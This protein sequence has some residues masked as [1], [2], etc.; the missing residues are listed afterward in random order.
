M[1]HHNIHDLYMSVFHHVCVR[2]FVYAATRV[3]AYV[4][5]FDIRGCRSSSD[6]SDG[7]GV[8]SLSLFV[9]LL[10]LTHIRPLFKQNRAKRRDLHTYDVSHTRSVN[11]SGHGWKLSPE[12]Q[13]DTCG[14]IGPDERRYIRDRR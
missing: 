13:I 14:T 7:S 1:C 5:A 3:H 4:R 10:L 9:L 12:T 2:S 11:I 6:A 8:S